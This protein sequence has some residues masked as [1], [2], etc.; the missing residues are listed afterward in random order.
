M[1]TINCVFQSLTLQHEWAN[2]WTL[3]FLESNL[4]LIAG[5]GRHTKL[6][7][8]KA[9]FSAFHMLLIKWLY[10]DIFIYLGTC[11]LILE[12]DTDYLFPADLFCL[13]QKW[14]GNN[15]GPNFFRK[16]PPKEGGRRGPSYEKN[17][18]ELKTWYTKY[19]ILQCT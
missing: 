18:V 5:I 3:D 11:H 12:S 7:F 10:Y 13:R 6:W 2:F 9:C 16:A 19:T 4:E 8:S 17:R 14:K 15:F 1:N